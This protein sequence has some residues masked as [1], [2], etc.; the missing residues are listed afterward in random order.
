MVEY[1]PILM[2][3]CLVK[4]LYRFCGVQ[5]PLVLQLHF[6]KLRKR[7]HHISHLFEHVVEIDNEAAEDLRL[8]KVLPHV[9]LGRAQDPVDIKDTLKEFNVIYFSCTS[10][11]LFFC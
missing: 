11:L 7:V 5:I 1:C 4:V 10:R 2:F 6:D 3:P 8:G 9:R